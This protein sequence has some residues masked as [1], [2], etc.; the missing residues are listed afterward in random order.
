MQF[1]LREPTQRSGPTLILTLREDHVGTG[2][3]PVQRS[4]APRQHR[5]SGMASSLNYIARFALL[6]LG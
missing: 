2:D 6:V 1:D 5:E 4:K 3:S